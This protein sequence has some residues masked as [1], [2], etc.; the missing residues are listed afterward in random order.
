MNWFDICIV[1]VIIYCIIKGYKTGLVKQLSTLAGLIVGAVLSGKLS[2]LILPYIQHIKQIPDYMTAPL[3]Y[4][5]T[6]LIIIS[7]FYLLGTMMEEILKTVKMGTLNKLAGV[8]L[9]LTKWLFVISIVI[10]L[11]VQADEHHQLLAPKIRNRSAT[12]KYI[13]PFAPKLVPF[14][15]F[16]FE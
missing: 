4:A 6:F 12:Y 1:I 3:S 15:K 9:C 7:S 8:V 5:L 14:L 10:N 16:N 11:I 2:V 13:Q